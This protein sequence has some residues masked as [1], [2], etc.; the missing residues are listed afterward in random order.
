MIKTILSFFITLLFLPFLGLSQPC[1]ITQV[2]ATP[3]PCNAL[4]F[5]VSVNLQVN[6]PASPGFTLAGNGVIYGTFLYSDLPIIVGPLLGD[7]ESSYE[8]IAW[9]VDNPGCQNFVKITA[10][11]CGPICDFSH[12]TM[13]MISCVTNNVA[14]VTIDFDHTET[15][16]AAFDIYYANG[17]YLTSALYASLPYDILNF[18]TN[19]AAPITVKICDKSNP[20]CCESFTVPAIDCNPNNCEIYNLIA[21]PECLSGN[22]VVHLDFDIAHPAS[23]SFTVHGNTLNYGTF[24]YNELPVVL[25]PLNGNSN[26]N[27]DFIIQDK[28]LPSCTKDYLLGIYHCPPP[29]NILSFDATATL[30]NGNNAYELLL[31]L[32]I[33]GKGHQGYSVFS[34]NYYYGTYNY[35]DLP[36]TLPAF[37][38]SG[39]FID[40]V[41]ICDNEYQG[42]CVT[43]AYEAL[44]CAGCIIYNLEA[45]PLP[46]DQD[47]NFFISID[48]D[49][50]NTSSQGFN[51]TGNGTSFGNFLYS[52]VPL[53]LGP[54][55]GEVS[56]F[57]EF[58]VTDIDNEFCFD[59]TEIGTLACFQ[60]SDIVST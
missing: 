17:Q 5:M 8:F 3:L 12:F 21:D 25:G 46:C 6:N 15:A 53:L 42:C 39:D 31:D 10:A 44:L 23:D 28:V 43:Q 37:V 40:Q 55:D 2:T 24:G 35:A 41:T 38:G 45:N 1:Q 36:Y 16:G 14:A 9:D 4:T 52:Q 32:D 58:V 57:F 26:I 49:F 54:F 13:H 22:F 34:D 29:C 59:A 11:D 47:G 51:I 48:F 7:N 56:Q 33:E 30:C 27:W 50:Q 19:G 18:T 20:T 60:T